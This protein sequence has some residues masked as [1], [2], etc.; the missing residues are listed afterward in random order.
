MRIIVHVDDPADMVFAMRA[1]LATISRGYESC[2]FGYGEPENAS[3]FVSRNKTGWT[4]W[5]ERPGAADHA[6]GGE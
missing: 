2:A 4:V 3:A 5:I 1:V 6:E